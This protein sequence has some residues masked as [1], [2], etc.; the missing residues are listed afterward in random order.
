MDRRRND[1][2]VKTVSPRHRTATSALRN[3]CFNCRA[4]RSTKDNVRC[5]AVEEQLEAKEVQLSQPSST[6][7]IMISSP[8]PP[9]SPSL[10]SHLASV[11]VNGPIKAVVGK[12]I[13]PNRVKRTYRSVLTFEEKKWSITH[14][15]KTFSVLRLGCNAFILAKRSE[16]TVK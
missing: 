9:L 11:D 13:A 6:S 5:T 2:N 16:N 10:I 4:G 14:L 15:F 3:C 7:L 1:G 8:T 12:R